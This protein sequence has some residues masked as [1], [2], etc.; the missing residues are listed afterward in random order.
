MR[1]AKLCYFDSFLA[2]TGYQ[3]QCHNTVLSYIQQ[4]NLIFPCILF[5]S[6]RGSCKQWNCTVVWDYLCSLAWSCFFPFLQSLYTVLSGSGQVS[7]LFQ[8]NGKCFSLYLKQENTLCHVTQA[9]QQ[10]TQSKWKFKQ[11]RISSGSVV[12]WFVLSC[13]IT[14]LFLFASLKCDCLQTKWAHWGGSGLAKTRCSVWLLWC[15]SAA[16]LGAEQMGVW[17]TDH[18]NKLS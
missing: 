11:P 3:V 15:L 10:V 8:H 14:F 13:N 12:F 2:P 18:P 1:L 5:V 9:W 7:G 16:G 4:N 6:S 17:H